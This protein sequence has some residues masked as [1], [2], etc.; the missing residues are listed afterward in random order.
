M[1]LPFWHVFKLRSY[2]RF[3]LSEAE[4]VNE[5]WAFEYCKTLPYSRFPSLQANNK[6]TDLN[7]ALSEVPPET[8]TAT[9]TQAQ[10]Y[11][12]MIKTTNQL[13][14]TGKEGGMK[15][16]SQPLSVLQKFLKIG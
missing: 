12:N 13:V 11:R 5:R 2:V 1:G 15:V 6:C 14:S 4:L 3:S 8:K 10:K 16:Y 9:L 7:V